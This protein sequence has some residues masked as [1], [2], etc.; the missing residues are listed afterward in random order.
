MSVLTRVV[1]SQY[2]ERQ[3]EAQSERRTEDGWKV[4][5]CL[6]SFVYHKL[7]RKTKNP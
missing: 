5:I 3:T 6:Q 4:G 1:Y 7:K 2:T